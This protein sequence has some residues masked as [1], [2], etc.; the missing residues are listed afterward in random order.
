MQQEK[1]VLPES[2]YLTQRSLDYWSKG[3]TLGPTEREVDLKYDSYMYSQPSGLKH[4]AQLEPVPCAQFLTAKRAGRLWGG[5]CDGIYCFSCGL[6]RRRTTISTT[7]RT[8]TILL[9]KAFLFRNI[10]IALHC[11]LSKN[12]F[13]V[14]IKSNFVYKCCRWKKKKSVY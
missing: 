5:E 4:K 12:V 6:D 3:L 7:N 9:G 1:T 14:L 11:Q 13:Q 2:F 8:V 10:Q